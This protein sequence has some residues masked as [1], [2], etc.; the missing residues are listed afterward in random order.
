MVMIELRPSE[1]CC[2]LVSPSQ[3]K[4]QPRC[5]LGDD[6]MRSRLINA[7][8]HFPM[9]S[10][11]SFPLRQ[12]GPWSGEVHGYVMTNTAQVPRYLRA[13]PYNTPPLSRACFCNLG[14]VPSLEE[15]DSNIR[16]RR[17]SNGRNPSSYRM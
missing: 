14:T 13:K 7:K 16:F 10:S 1:R 5:C 2:V 8:L 4:L 9:P 6:A 15:A 11:Q 17:T 3:S 12:A